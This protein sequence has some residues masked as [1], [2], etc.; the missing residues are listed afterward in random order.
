MKG[1]RVKISAVGLDALRQSGRGRPDTLPK[2]EWRGLIIGES[3]DRAGWLVRWDHKVSAENFHKSY[4][5]FIDENGS[6]S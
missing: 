6:G 1:R 3:E 2:A 4:V 5:E